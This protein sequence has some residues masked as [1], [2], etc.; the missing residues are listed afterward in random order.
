MTRIGD[1]TGPAVDPAATVDL[2]AIRLTVIQLLRKPLLVLATLLMAASFAVVGSQWPGVVRSSIQGL[3]IACIF[4]CIFG[5]TW[6]SAYIGGRKDVSLVTVGPYSVC[7]NPLYAFSILGAVG[8]GAQLGSL[9]GALV[10]GALAWLVMQL[11]VLQE[12][13]ILRDVHGAPYREYCAR[14]PRF[15]PRF[16]L[17]RGP[18]VIEV[19]MSRVLRTFRDAC[20]FLLAIPAGEAVTYLHH[21][22]LLPEL[23][24]IP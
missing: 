17:W 23:L 8:V 14:V 11:V 13:K 7:R 10:V 2:S 22:G 4:V 21:A 15:L 6:C 3:G 24:R 16:S 5:R 9:S 18:D 1:T 19:R 20:V 12:E